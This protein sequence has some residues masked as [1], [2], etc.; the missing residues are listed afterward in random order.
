MKLLRR[1][2]LRL[3]ALV[4]VIGA[5]SLVT[6]AAWPQPTGTIRIVVPFPPGGCA[7][8]LA[9]LLAEQ[10]GRTQNVKIVV[11]NRPGADTVIGTEAASHAAPDG[12]T[13]LIIANPFVTNPHLAKVNYDPLTSFEPI[14]LLASSPTVIV[15]NGNS[16]YRTL[17]DLVGAARA[18]PG[19]LTLASINTFRIAFEM[20]QRTADVKMTFIP[21]PGNAPAVSAL[22]GDHVTSVFAV[23]P[24]VA[25]QV[26]AGALP[27]LVTTSR[28]RIE[29]LPEL[30]TA[31]ESG[32]KDYSE[33]A[34]FGLVA[35]SKTPKAALSRLSALFTASIRAPETKPKLAAQ[36]L[37]PAGTC[38]AEF[39]AFLRKQ[40][41]NDGRLIREAN[42]K[43]P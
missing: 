35:P 19:E 10:I 39:G 32:Y 1:Q 17:A 16:P 20:F 2:S 36:G 12:N 43:T 37:Y 28:V 30:P 4:A 31:G 11:E 23:Y 7:D 34:W 21:Y 5:A 41:D 13:I 9:R 6:F 42:I 24:T 27:A 15:V 25:E 22:R 33:E 29:T 40:Y 14:C 3:A 38:D 18:K 26:K 8:I